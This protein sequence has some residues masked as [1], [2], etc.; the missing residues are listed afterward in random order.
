MDGNAV[1]TTSASSVTMNAATEV[2]STVGTRL[3]DEIMSVGRREFADL[4][5]EA[6]PGVAA[7]TDLACL[8]ENETR[9]DMTPSRE[10]ML[11]FDQADTG[12]GRKMGG[13]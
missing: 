6:S 12:I 8:A 5:P 1:T 10:R 3:R 7:V 13:S 11:L 9:H 2:S 4:D